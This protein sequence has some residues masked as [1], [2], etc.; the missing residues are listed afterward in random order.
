MEVGMRRVLLS[1]ISVLALSVASASAA[2]IPRPAPTYRAPVA[3]PM[4]F[5][6]TGG[7][8]G[9]NAGYGW[10]QSDWGFFGG[11]PK[12]SGGLVGATLGYNW[13]ALGSPWVF[14]LEG[15]IQWSNIN[16]NFVNGLCA[17]GCQIKTDW[18]GTVRGRVGYA[19][20]RVMA[21]ATGGLA[22]GDVKATI[23]GFGGNSDTNVGWTVGAGLE[24]AIAPNWTAKIEYLYV[25]L[26]S[27]SC[28]VALCAPV[29]GGPIFP[30]A[31]NIDFTMHVV[32]AGLNYKF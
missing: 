7:Y 16:G 18:F 2:D 27:T 21:Y 19:W 22:F 5:N 29:V 3:V 6:W 4:M 32:R 12:P 17:F 26:G 8:I 24:G 31:N 20:D 14:G 1:T 13:Q 15:D 10:G 23:N 25:D 30:I 9:V 11:D 28:G